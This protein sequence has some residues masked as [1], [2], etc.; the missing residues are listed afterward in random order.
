MTKSNILLFL[1]TF[2]ATASVFASGP[3]PP[4]PGA[5]VPIDGGVVLLV[6]A[7]A[8]YGVSRLKKEKKEE[9]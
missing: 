3:V 2:V 8:A 5:P 1:L 9:I 4:G 7:G 6:A